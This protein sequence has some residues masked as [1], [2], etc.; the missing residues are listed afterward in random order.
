MTD[1]S[2]NNCGRTLRRGG[3]SV[4]RCVSAPTVCGLSPNST[5]S[6]CFEFEMVKNLQLGKRR[7]QAAKSAEL[8]I[9]N[10]HRFAAVATGFERVRM[11]N[12]DQKSI[13]LPPS[14]GYCSLFC[15]LTSLSK[16]QQLWL[17]DDGR[18][19]QQLW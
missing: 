15:E 2:F 4:S 17:G 12:V 6:I 16:R 11:I 3:N 10:S 19:L 1:V 5:Q 9:V 18:I 7:T 14:G 13:S 8:L